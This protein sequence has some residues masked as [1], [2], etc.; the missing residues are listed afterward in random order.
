MAGGGGGGA[1]RASLYLTGACCFTVKTSFWKRG[2]LEGVS[3]TKHI[4]EELDVLGELLR[5]QRLGRRKL[6][7][8][9]ANGE[10]FSP[11][12]EYSELLLSLGDGRIGPRKRNVLRKTVLEKTRTREQ[13]NSGVRR[14]KRPSVRARRLGKVL[15]KK[16]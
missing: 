2:S 13:R 10:S 9:G 1:T 14:E 15:K 4:G 5:G 7:G 12:S 11:T 6:E 8:S 16:R 3:D